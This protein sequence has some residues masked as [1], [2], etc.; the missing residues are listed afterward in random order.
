MASYE[1]IINQHE[2]LGRIVTADSAKIALVHAL[3][4]A[5]QWVGRRDRPEDACTIT[6]SVVNVGR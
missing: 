2:E 3:A 4:E 5:T 6:I 1:I